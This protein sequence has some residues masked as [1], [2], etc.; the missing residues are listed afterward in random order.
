MRYALGN[1][2]VKFWTPIEWPFKY[3]IAV[4]AL[5]VYLYVFKIKY[6]TGSVFEI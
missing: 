4:F 5:I 2:G 6:G 3:A 1:D